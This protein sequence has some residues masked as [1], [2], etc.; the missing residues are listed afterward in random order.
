MQKDLDSLLQETL[1]TFWN[2]TEFKPIQKE[3]IHSVITG[4]DTLLLL[5]T[6]GGKSLCYQLP[7]LVLEGTCL[8]ISPLLALIKDQVNA[9]KSIGIDAAYVTSEM[10]DL[11]IET[12]LH[13]CRDGYI[14][15]LYVSPERLTNPYFL[16]KL[17]EIKVSFIAVDEAH[18]ITEWGQ[19]FRPSYKN[20]KPFRERI[21]NVPII[22]LTATA[23]K[24][25]ALEIE[26]KLGLQ[27]PNI[28]RRSYK[29]AN[30][31][32]IIDEITDKYQR[33]AEYLKFSNQSGIIYTRTRKEAE[34]LSKF[35]HSRGISNQDFFH[36]GLH[37]SIKNAKQKKWLSSSNQV[38][39]ATNAFGMGIDK[40]NVRFVIH[41]NTPASIENYYQEI[42]RA[43]RDHLPSQAI[44]FWNDQE[45][46]NFTTMLQNQIPN[47]NEFLKVI[48]AIYSKYFVAEGE[49]LDKTFSFN[50]NAI[51][52]RTQVSVSKIKNILT[53]LNNQEIIY[54]N[55]MPGKSSL[56]LNISLREIEE[57]HPKIS[58]F[59]ETLIRNLTGLSS[60]KVY[61]KMNALSQKLRIDE[62]LLKTKFRE[63]QDNGF[64]TFV[65]GTESTIKFITERNTKALGGMWWNLFLQIQKS[66]LQK[67]AEMKFF[68]TDKEYC[69]MRLILSYFGEKQIQNC[70]LCNICE[71]KNTEVFG[72]QLADKILEALKQSPATVEELSFKLNYP[73]RNKIL[74][75]LILLLDAEKIKMQNFRTYTLNN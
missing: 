21:K 3:S 18:C 55:F 12:V 37:P 13:R 71:S 35:L 34:K 36:A 75:N 31:Q 52:Q 63:L 14:K 59:L 23:T 29:R 46:S 17:E 2:Y 6:G 11:E 5:P 62:V 44:L 10:E 64:I 32:I 24:K 67:W 49:K 1:K 30:I 25:V 8:V 69:K 45:L 48:S 47:K 72:S 20:I 54:Y 33:I 41:F 16:Q 22:A 65:D 39:I 26:E 60:G 73:E 43:G 53:F 19:D 66:K 40:E 42:G 9:L 70:D 7:A 50:L 4:I 38:L 74:E 68:L 15:I 27:N 57:L 51:Q 28:F 58:Y 56:E 61:F